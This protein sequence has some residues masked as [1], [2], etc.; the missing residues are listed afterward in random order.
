MI[1][2]IT[3]DGDAVFTYILELVEE[4][5]YTRRDSVLHIVT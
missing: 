2:Q 4:N 1:L 5:M 3:I